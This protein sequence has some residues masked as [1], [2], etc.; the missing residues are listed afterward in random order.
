MAASSAHKGAVKERAEGLRP[1]Y[2]AQFSRGY[3]QKVTCQR[4]WCWPK[5]SVALV[6]MRGENLKGGGD[7]TPDHQQAQ[8]LRANIVVKLLE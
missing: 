1:E 5:F 6:G 7:C 4:G 3:H 2:H 8:R